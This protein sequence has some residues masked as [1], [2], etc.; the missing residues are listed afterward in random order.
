MS[1]PTSHDYRWPPCRAG[2]TRGT[3]VPCQHSTATCRAVPPCRPCRA[4]PCYGP[5]LQPMT[6]HMGHL[7]VSCRPCR[8]WAAV[9][10][11]ELGGRS[12][13]ERE[14]AGRVRRGEEA[15][16]RRCGRR[17]RR[18]GLAVGMRGEKARCG[19]AGRAVSW[20]RPAAHDPHGP[21]C[22]ASTG[23]LPAV[24]CRPWAV[25]KGRVVGRAAG[26]WAV[27]TPIVMI[28]KVPI[29]MEWL[30]YDVTVESRNPF[31]FVY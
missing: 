16:R 6:Q 18:C 25:P 31:I 17:Q 24:P 26:P 13:K 29:Q 15:R 9:H 20:A 19:R 21:S 28:E 4:R 3:A 14:R 8:P 23:T 2:T 12:W 5:G 30:Q 22:H 27:C 10:A 11:C 1:L 7:P